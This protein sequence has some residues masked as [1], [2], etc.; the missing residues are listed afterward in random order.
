MA[1]QK[2]VEQI[3]F[4]RAT[5]ACSVLFYH[6]YYVYKIYNQYHSFELEYG[7]L[8]VQ[9]FFIISGFVMSLPG[10]I[11]ED[12]ISFIKKRLLRIFPAYLLVTIIIAPVYYYKYSD[13]FYELL[14]FSLLLIPHWS[15]DKFG[16]HPILGVGWTL[17]FE[18]IFYYMIFT[19]LFFKIKKP[20]LL[21]S[22]TLTALGVMF[23]FM[24]IEGVLGYILNPF[25]YVFFLLGAIFYRISLMKAEK[26][27]YIAI[28]T[29]SFFIVVALR[30][31]GYTESSHIIQLFLPISIFLAPFVF[32]F[33][34]LC[35]SRFILFIASVSYEIYLVHHP[36]ISMLGK[37]GLAMGS[38]AAFVFMSLFF[39]I[40]FAYILNRSVSLG[41]R[42]LKRIN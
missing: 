6:A 34:F 9:V 1:K 11:G 19:M 38:F 20:V 8:G 28:F 18:L 27:I 32:K 14:A 22:L 17:Q 15:I 40:V 13:I 29:L 3:Q 30:F 35:N 26:F 36:I 5:A 12:W 2:L 21:T 33:I 31:A 10:V 4:L 16:F 37:L 24:Q 7:F 23:Q 41:I 42:S 39:S 25:I